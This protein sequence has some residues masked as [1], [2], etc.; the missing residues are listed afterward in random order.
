MIALNDAARNI[1]LPR[2]F[3]ANNTPATIQHI[4]IGADR[5]EHITAIAHES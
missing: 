5:A 4:R 3:I 2:P 1:S